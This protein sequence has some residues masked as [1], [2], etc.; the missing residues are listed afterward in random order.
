MKKERI[1]PSGLF[2][3]HISIHIEIAVLRTGLPNMLL[4]FRSRCWDFNNADKITRI[5]EML[6]TEPQFVSYRPISV[7]VAKSRLH[8]RF[9]IRV[10]TDIFIVLGCKFRTPVREARYMNVL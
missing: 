6:K 3:Y 5:Y 4:Y 9:K 2:G 1:F 10:N 7:R 8:F